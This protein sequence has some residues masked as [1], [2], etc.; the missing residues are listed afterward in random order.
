MN[1]VASRTEPVITPTTI[2]FYGY[3]EEQTACMDNPT[4]HLPP[5]HLPPC[6]VWANHVAHTLGF[7]VVESYPNAFDENG[8]FI[9]KRLDTGPDTEIRH[10]A[11]LAILSLSYEDEIIVGIPDA[12]AYLQFY[13]LIQPMLTMQADERFHDDSDIDGRWQNGKSWKDILEVQTQR[14]KQNQ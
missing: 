6:R 2:D 7:E 10:F 8:C 14:V 13:R 3:I 1:Y 12:A 9:L 5:S 11:Y 4:S